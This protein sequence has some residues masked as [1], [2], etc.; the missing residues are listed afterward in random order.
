[1]AEG[2]EGEHNPLEELQEEVNRLRNLV[3]NAGIGQGAAPVG[4]VVVTPRKLSTFSGEFPNKLSDWIVEARSAVRSQRLQD[5]D[6]VD[7]L[8]AHLEGVARN[9]VKFANPDD[10]ATAD[11]VFE[12]LQNAFGEKLSA[13]QV[14]DMFHART[15]KEG[16]SLRSFA[17]ALMELLTRATTIDEECVADEDRL[18][19]EKFADKVKDRNLRREL[20]RIIR[21]QPDMNFRELLQEAI[22]SSEEDTSPRGKYAAN[23]QIE[24]GELQT[25]IQ[26]QSVLTKILETQ[27]EQQKL[28][29][30]QQEELFKLVNERKPS[31]QNPRRILG[32]CYHCK[33][34]GHL[35][36]KCPALK[37]ERK[38]DPPKET[39]H[40]ADSKEVR[41]DPESFIEKTVGGKPIICCKF[42]DVDVDCL[43][44][45]GSQVTTITESF[46]RSKLEPMG[47]AI[48]VGNQFIN[49]SAANNLEIPYLGVV[50]L[51]V[52][53]KEVTV[54]DRGVL[55]AKDTPGYQKKYPGILG[56]NVIRYVTD[57]APMLQGTTSQSNVTESKEI[58]T[59]V[60]KL[61]G[62][63]P[64]V[65][66]GASVCD[67]LATSTIRETLPS[68]V[69]GLA[70]PYKGITIA[71]TLVDVSRGSTYVR[72]MNSSEEDI[73]LQPR[74]RIGLT[75]PIKYVNTGISALQM[76]MSE[77]DIQLSVPPQIESSE[78][79]VNRSD[80]VSDTL[81]EELD[82]KNFEGTEEER[83][84]LENLIRK[85]H[86]VFYKPGDELGSTKTLQHRIIMEDESPISQPYRRVPPYLW[87][88]LKDHLSDLLQRGVIRESSSDFASPVVLV[89]KP[90][91]AL[92]MC[93][94][95]RKVNAKV[96]RDMYPLPRIDQTFDALS[97][98]KYF[99]TLDLTAAYN[100]VEVHK[101]DQHK[102]A[103]ITPMGL[104]EY[105]RMPFGLS[106]APATFQRLMGRVFREEILQ[107]LL[108]YLDDVVVYS[109]SV[110]EHFQRLEKVFQKLR[111]HGLKLSASKCS[112]FRKE[113]KFL[114]HI[115][116]AQGIKTDPEKIVAVQAWPTPKT[117][118][119][120][121]QFLGLAS[122]YR[123]FVSGFAEIAAP[124][125]ELVGLLTGANK[126]KRRTQIGSLWKSNHEA[127]FKEL[128][129]K[130]TS[131]PILGYANFND[132]F[133]LETDA[134]H[135]GLGAILSQVQEGVP[136]VIAY[137][138]RGLRK[139]ERNASNYSS[140][141]LEMLAL[142]WAVEKL[143]DYLLP[144]SFVVLTDSNPLTYLMSKNKLSAMDQRWAST[145][146]SYNF[147]FK[148][149]PGKE[150]KGADALSRQND[151][152]WDK[153]LDEKPEYVCAEAGNSWPLP[154]EL[155]REV[156]QEAQETDLDIPNPKDGPKLATSLPTVSAQEIKDMQQKDSYIS[157][158][159][160]YLE[161]I[162][163]PPLNF[164]VKQPKLTQLL[165]RQWDRL[166]NKEGVVYRHVKDPE[167][168]PLQ[169]LVLPQRLKES[170]LK[171]YHDEQGHQGV[172]RTTLLIRKKCYW[173]R[174][175]KDIKTWINTCERCL[176]AKP[177]KVKTPMGSILACRPMEV[178]AM[179]YT[180]LEPASDGR[181][182]V[183]VLTDVFT[184]FTI[185]VATRDQ[186]ATTVAKVL[187]KEWFL[188]FGPPKRLH[189]DQ[190]RDFESRV[191]KE[192]CRL[193][194]VAKSHSTPYH[195]A[196]NGQVERYNRTLHDLLRTLPPK[197]K[198]R[199]PEHL[200]ALTFAYNATPH[201]STGFSPFYLLFGRDPRLP[202]D[203]LLGTQEEQ[204]T[205]EDMTDF[206][207]N[208]QIKLQKAF[209]I[210]KLKLE[211]SAVIRG[212]YANRTAKEHPLFI[213][214]KVLLKK[215]G[216]TGRHKISDTYHDEVYKVIDQR[217]NQDVYLIEKSDGFGPQKWVNRK[218][219]RPCDMMREKAEV[220]S[221]RKKDDTIEENSSS[222]EDE[223]NL[224]HVVHRLGPELYENPHP[225]VEDLGP[226]EFVPEPDMNMPEEPDNVPELPVVP[227]VPRR[228]ARAGAGVH[229]NIHHL[230]RPARIRCQIIRNCE[231]L[232]NDESYV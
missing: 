93:V 184:K 214:Q 127:A 80:E 220:A 9:E 40:P 135:E 61:A 210:V 36:N 58:K 33:E 120:L 66:P 77:K 114:G 122:Y 226:E 199:W 168:G 133:I 125:H 186:K 13:T 28:L 141:R 24:A 86:D 142:T 26:S 17:H 148:Y 108:V 187:V 177:I 103:F 27:Q 123:R 128:K 96:K 136:R 205:F 194:G 1:M 73:V 131:A 12:I 145:L 95:Y 130:L 197:A 124:L 101:D 151:R 111:E 53:I 10:R 132:S 206:V 113:V 140:K 193:Y 109:R 38:V 87:Q 144:C 71:P 94:D 116:S 100:Q 149:R 84:Q 115:V 192:L 228:T 22:L 207:R 20:K 219:L 79:T 165:V 67:I 85:Y 155:Q 43:L 74:T 196:G 198:R 56:M 47:K 138:S 70:N 72:V 178:V 129:A 146:A 139:N 6:S 14:L 147:T 191:V 232:Y 51:D 223:E 57:F 154:L 30:K 213:G 201:A 153:D 102:T 98:A 118:L 81:P 176:K 106:N 64:V 41:V 134:S 4:H 231:I 89:R 59:G 158:I 78:Q 203:G 69:E 171:G 50:L 68:L 7:F 162:Q 209:A 21:Q 126:G 25:L 18:L 161:R 90:T 29:L 190:G 221:K 173:P 227:V 19:K 15:Q 54:P 169:Q 52:K 119:E 185:A 110:Q 224:V 8:R 164:R 195:P 91:G 23:H 181:E 183:L 215:H 157:P 166:V 204:D 31:G 179:D 48:S 82:L 44:D 55:V 222:E 104:Y 60:M 42:G 156:L 216:F 112:F 202:T 200:E 182:N 229:S 163:K 143:R 160:P 63:S 167:L 152:P 170:I 212:K 39:Q 218:E 188:K 45:T 3:A 75:R 65:I 35:R 83:E 225:I 49:L 32:P 180:V 34:M 174:M 208:H 117:L 62:T 76:S 230:P 189:S 121:R 107:I 11:Q 88:E 46:Y 37:N 137:I 172:E 2:G 150:N 175:D 99:T 211:Q 97:G 105:Q 217:E 5:A 159:L 16:E 92:R